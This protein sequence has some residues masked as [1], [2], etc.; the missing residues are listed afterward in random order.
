MATAGPSWQA[1]AFGTILRLRG[2]KKVLAS[3]D[4]TRARVAQRALRPAPYAPPKSLE[5][6]TALTADLKGDWPL[7]DIGPTT[8]AASRRVLYLHGGC[9]LLEILPAHWRFVAQLAR[10]ASARVTVPIYPL[11]PR[12]HASDLVPATADLLARVIEEAGADNMI[13]MGDSA[14]GGLA[15][16]TAQYLRDHHGLQPART[17]LI[18]PWLDVT[19]NHPD[20]VAIEPL[21]PMLA[22]PGL[23]EAGRLYAGGL[24]PADPLVSPLHGTMQGL[25]P[26]TVLC[27][28]HDILVTDSRALTDKARAAGVPVDYHEAAAMP[29][30]FPLMP[31][32]EGRTARALVIDACR[33]P[34]RTVL[35]RLPHP[36]EP[37]RR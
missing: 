16:A 29:H 2:G 3:A 26:L 19:T 28:T 1:R 8:E 10:R 4:H 24:D 21:D 33:V 23:V 5:R 30:V 15:L 6:G 18:S 14:G 36:D 20:Q 13:L 7:Y 31:T 32:P 22:R 34:A 27:G 25:A 11:A 12:R 17:V 37:W 35:S 9:Y